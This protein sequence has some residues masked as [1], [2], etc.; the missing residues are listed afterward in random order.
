M[1]ESRVKEYEKLLEN[2][3]NEDEIDYSD[4]P[5]DPRANGK[6]GDVMLKELRQ[7]HGVSKKIKK[8]V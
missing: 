8:D 4:L 1:D 2:A 7:K 6:L 5:K 3:P